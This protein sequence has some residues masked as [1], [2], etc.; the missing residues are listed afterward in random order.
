MARLFIIGNGFDVAHGYST[1]YCHFRDW[2]LFRLAEMGISEDKLD[3]IPE[4]PFSF[5]GNHDEEYN[6]D[7]LIKMLMW[8]LQYGSPIDDEWNKFESAL[9]ELD[10]Q[11]VLDEATAYR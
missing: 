7:E 6:Q 4:I 8:L 1:K 9:Y 10:L 3:E 11:A 5:M 2:I